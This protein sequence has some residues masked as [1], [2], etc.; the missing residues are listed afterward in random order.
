VLIVRID[1][2]DMRLAKEIGE[3]FLQRNKVLC[4]AWMLF[5]HT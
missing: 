1:V 2:E 5:E 4:V 3:E